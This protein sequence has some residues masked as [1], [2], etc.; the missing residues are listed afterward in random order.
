MANTKLSNVYGLEKMIKGVPS[1]IDAYIEETNE[2]VEDIKAK[3]LYYSEMSAVGIL[4]CIALILIGGMII[5]FPNLIEEY[6]SIDTNALP[7]KILGVFL[8]LISLHG[9]SR[10]LFASKV[11]S[12]FKNLEKMRVAFKSQFEG[13]ASSLTEGNQLINKIENF[14]DDELSESSKLDDNLFHSISSLQSRDHMFSKLILISR[15]VLPIVLYV[16]ALMVIIKGADIGVIRITIA[17]VIMFIFNSRLCLL[18]EYKVGAIVRAAMCLPSVAYGIIAYLSIKEETYGMNF[19]PHTTIMKL[20]SGVLNYVSSGFVVCVVQVAVLILTI[21]F[22]DYYSEKVHWR[23]G[24]LVKPKETDK[25]KK[26]FIIYGIVLY[27]VLISAYTIA[28]VMQKEDIQYADSIK[29]VLILGAI[30]GVIWRIISPIWPE[31][32]SKTIRK[33]W[34]ARYTIAVELFVV[35]IIFTLF[36]LSGFVFSVYSF[37]MLIA[38]ILS[39]WIAFAVMVHFWG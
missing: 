5:F 35:A 25:R 16:S 9:I 13:A 10:M 30:F 36:V 1:K 28:L 6:T 14:E 21:A 20:P 37:I 27:A 23:E 7:F 31:K 3:S 17:F 12:T 24:I 39:S 18:L 8:F 19:L 38:I 34:G 15:I 29:D 32:I 11:D 33:F 4:T 22:R 2:E 26:W